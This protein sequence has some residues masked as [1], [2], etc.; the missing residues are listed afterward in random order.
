MIIELILPAVKPEADQLQDRQGVIQS[1]TQ[2]VHQFSQIAE[3]QMRVD[4]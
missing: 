3:I 2:T 4:I 1:E